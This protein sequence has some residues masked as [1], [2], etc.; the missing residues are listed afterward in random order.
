[1]LST[2]HQRHPFLQFR[3]HRQPSRGSDG[4][5]SADWLRLLSAPEMPASEKQQALFIKLSFVFL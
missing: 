3:M 5:D 1:L 4:F 2:S